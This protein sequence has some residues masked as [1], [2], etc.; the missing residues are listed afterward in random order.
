MPAGI[1]EK[2]GED[3]RKTQPEIFALNKKTSSGKHSS[4]KTFLL[5]SF[6]SS[7]VEKNKI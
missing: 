2:R 4:S 7:S 1:R 3:E 6:P 5:S